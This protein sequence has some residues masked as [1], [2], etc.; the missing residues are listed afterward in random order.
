[1]STPTIALAGNPNCGKTTLFNALTGAHARV[2]NYPGITVERKSATV[3]LPGRGRVELVDV[4]GTASLTAHTAEE[5]VAVAALAG[6]DGPPPDVVLLVVD[7]TQLARHLYLVL[8]VLELRV[9]VVVAVNMSDELR[10]AGRDVD[11]H[12]LSR[13]LGVPCVPVS[14][15]R[16]EGLDELRAALA[17]ALSAPLTVTGRKLATAVNGS[18]G[19]GLQGLVARIPEA[20]SRGDALRGRALAEWAMLSLDEPDELTDIP[21]ELRSDARRV[22]ADAEAAGEDIELA[23]VAPRYAWIDEV[24]PQVCGEG[25][26]VRRATDRL[27]KLLVHPLLG[28]LAFVAIM[29]TMFEALFTW[30]GPLIDAVDGAVGAFGAQ[31]AAWLPDGLL[32]DVIVDGLVAGVGAVVVFLPQILLL[33]LFVSILEDSGYMARAALLMD[34]VMRVFG[35]SGRAFVP[36]LSG[37]ACAIPA[38]M[39]TRTLERYRDRLVVMLAVPLTTC[40]ARLPVYTLLIAALYPASDEPGGQVLGVFSLQGVLMVVMYLLG[41]VMSLGAAGILGKL[42]FK[43]APPPLLLE[44]PP[45]RVPQVR[46]VLRTMWERGRLFLTEAG[47][48]I[49]ACSVVLWALVTFPL[50]PELSVDYAAEAAAVETR[51]ESEGWDDARRDEALV[52]LEQRESS[53]RLR[54][55]YAGRIGRAMEPAIEPLGFDWQIGVGLLGA[56]A[57]REVFVSTLGIVYGVGDEVDEESSTLREKLKAETRADGS[58]L[59]TPLVG[60]SLLV[61][62]ALAAQCMSTLAVVKRETGGYRWPVALFAGLTVVAWLGSFVVYQGGLLLGLG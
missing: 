19:D 10:A 41:I 51:A 21:H 50:E 6:F 55:S 40:A 5:R 48:V 34:R 62:F 57:A 16:R 3:E 38:I 1:M 37:F 24:L 8:Q 58:P 29:A 54:Q 15:R 14:A 22:R 52:Q 4:P 35:L 30:S 49:L 2:G 42:L 59:Y 13:R 27:D 45:Y 9:P 60:L 17:G 18:L 11:V 32:Q 33:F 39:A 28:M 43:A 53:E 7:G 12:Q 44:L 36:M 20:W 25:G 46:S 47:T 31:L 23:L 61:F 56:F 26:W